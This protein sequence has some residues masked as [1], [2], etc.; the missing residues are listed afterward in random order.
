MLHRLPHVGDWS[1]SHCGGALSRADCDVSS[2]GGHYVV[3]NK[4]KSDD[5]SKIQSYVSQNLATS[6]DLQQCLPSWD[7]KVIWNHL[8][9]FLGTS[10]CF[11][12]LASLMF[13]SRATLC[14][15]QVPPVQFLPSVCGWGMILKPRMILQP[16]PDDS[17][18]KT[19]DSATKSD[20]ETK[21]NDSETKDDSATKDTWKPK[22]HGLAMNLDTCLTCQKPPRI[23]RRCHVECGRKCVRG[24]NA[25][26][27]TLLSHPTPPHPTPPHP[28][29]PHPTPR[30]WRRCHVECGRKCVRGRNAAARTLLSHPTLPHPTPPPRICSSNAAIAMQQHPSNIHQSVATPRYSATP[31]NVLIQLPNVIDT[32]PKR[33]R[34]KKAFNISPS[35]IFP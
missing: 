11:R 27:R 26:A 17:E 18:T 22:W 4:Y 2:Q 19:D 1:E 28:T 29:A 9:S 16:K 35:H 20:S 25:A 15:R 34:S 5:Y 8:C 23:W 12:D 14:T 21:K 10:G 6:I 32:I 31:W 33:W 30:M 3:Q 13:D 7:R 24:R